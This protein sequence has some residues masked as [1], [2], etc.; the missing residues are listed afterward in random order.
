MERMERAAGEP[1][2]LDLEHRLLMPD[3]AV[4]HVHVVARPIHHAATGGMEYVGAITDVTAVKESRQALE[5][6]YAEIRE[7]K[8]QL[9][10]ENIVLREE[11]D[12]TSMFEE[13]V[14]SS[15]P[16]RAVLSDLSKVA[17]T[18]STVLITGENRHGQ[19]AHRPSHP[20]AIAAIVSCLRQRQLRGDSGLTHRVGALRPREGRVYRSPAAATRPLRAG[21]RRDAVPRRGRRVARRDPDHAAP[22]VARA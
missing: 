19:G 10:K 6:A 20:Q 8:D 7:L 14:G 16:L 13:I 15:P 18:D 1:L 17:P 22:R 11:V 2:F 9:Q 12:K 4:K 21:R 5:H 3:G